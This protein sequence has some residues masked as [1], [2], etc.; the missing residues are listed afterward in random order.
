M[1][2]NM[3]KRYIGV[4]GLHVMILLVGIFGWILFPGCMAGDMDYDTAA[5]KL[6]NFVSSKIDYKINHETSSSLAGLAAPSTLAENLPDISEYPLSVDPLGNRRVDSSREAVVEIFASTEKSSERDPDNWLVRVA[7]DFNNQDIKLSS[8]K[9]ARVIIRKI[10]SGDGYQFIAARKYV[11]DAFTPSNHLWIKMVEASG[12]NVT[13]FSEKMVGNVAGI[14]MKKTV[15]D[16]LKEQ[17]GN[18]DVTTVLKAVV[19]AV[20]DP[21]FDFAMGYTN[22]FASSTGLNFLITVLA[23]YA[24]G[25]HNEM[26]APAV[27]SAFEAF[28]QGVPFVAMTTLQMRTSAENNGSLDAF[29]MENQ[30]FYKSS[31]LRSKYTFIPFGIRHDNPLYALGDLPEEKKEVLQKLTDYCRSGSVTR[32]AKEYGFNQFPTYKSSYDLPPGNILVN[33]QQ[34]WKKK[35]DSGRPIVAVFLSDVSGSMNN[36]DERGNVPMTELKKALLNGSTFI[37]EENYIGLVEFNNTVT[38]RLPIDRFNTSQK[39]KFAAA[40]EKMSP[41]G[42]TAMYDGILV[43][44]DMLTRAMQDIPNGKPM[45]FALTD[46]ATNEGAVYSQVVKMIEGLGIPVYTIGYNVNIDELE[47]IA[48]LTEAAY[49]NANAEGIK[50]KIGALL[51]A[52]M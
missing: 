17:Y 18:V 5:K 12:I 13:S 9:V 26:L 3:R 23:L 22:P 32:L 20:N 47:K 33:A 19:N 16:T 46:G 42:R 30:S 40:V 43:S 29:V 49:M 10:A 41:Q 51:N 44:L 25:D 21:E 34:L 38:V 35:K 27:V 50:Y 2:V 14:V 24:G 28:Q 52:E 1:E 31:V 36:P 6:H 7:E 37:A 4:N 8:G 45:L 48:G 15:H 11:P 39:G